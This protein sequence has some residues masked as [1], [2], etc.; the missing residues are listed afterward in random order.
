MSVD[1]KIALASRKQLRISNEEDIKRM[2]E[3][4][5]E[6][7]AVLVGIET[8]ISDNPKLTVKKKYVNNP[9]QPIRVVLDSNFR[10]P[11]NS[12]VLNDDTKTLILTIRDNHDFNLEN[13]EIIRCKTDENGNVD[14]QY[15]LSI[16]YSKKIRKLLVEG[17][18]T[19]I[20][21]FLKR[22]FVDD[23][24][25]YMGPIIIGGKFTPTMADGVGIN[26]E[27]EVINLK[28]VKFSKLGD[29]ILF[30]YKMIR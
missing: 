6:C 18:G 1:G 11:K 5:N 24:Y 2:Y 8:V 25:I 15:A 14:L 27:N 21:S 22:K 29:G 28:I 10:I 19:V 13:V 4:R 26:K 12:L 23:L 3:L 30:H 16:L 20:W 7:D 17:G 9:K